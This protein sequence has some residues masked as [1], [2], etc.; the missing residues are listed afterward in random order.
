M[1]SQFDQV[2][3][4]LKKRFTSPAG[5]MLHIQE[6]VRSLPQATEYQS[7]EDTERAVDRLRSVSSLLALHELEK[8]FE[9]EIFRAFTSKIPKWLSDN[10]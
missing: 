8:T 10:M 5:I 2:V 7:L 9:L 6:H 1:V 4:F 3:E